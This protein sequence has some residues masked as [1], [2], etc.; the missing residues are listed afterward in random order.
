MFNPMYG[1]FRLASSGN[2]YY[3]EPK[4]I[5]QQESQRFFY[6]IG[7]IVGKALHDEYLLECYFVKSLY[8]MIIGQPLTIHDVED[9]DN[10]MYKS[11]KWLLENDADE[12]G[13]NFVAE[14]DYFGKTE[15]VDLIENGKNTN[16]TNENK[17][18]YCMKKAFHLLYKSVDQQ[19]QQFLKGFYEVV[20]PKLVRL[21]EAS[22]LELLISGLPTI[23]IEDL[24]ENIEVVN[25]TTSS[26]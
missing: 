26:P 11:M 6:F 10:E 15:E 25:Y 1:L 13:L 2:T 5:F 7:R 22:E 4:S 20:P 23:D 14:F 3:P 12:L 8:K 16:V 19:I 21:F 24:F 18:E 9:F 17:K